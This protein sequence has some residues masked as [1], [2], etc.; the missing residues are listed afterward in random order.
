MNWWRRSLTVANRARRGQ[1]QAV[2]VPNECRRIVLDSLGVALGAVDEPKGRIGIEYGCM[3]GGSG[4]ATIIGI[5]DRVNIFGAAFANGELIKALDMD[6]VLPPGHVSPYVVPGALAVCETLG[7][8]GKSLINALAV[9]HEMSHRLGKAM[10][11]LR[12]TKGGKVSPPPV[13]G[14]SSTV[15][16]APAAIALLK[17]CSREVL[18]TAL[19]T[20]ASISPVNSQVGWFR[21]APR[22]TIKYLLA[23]GALSQPAMTAALMA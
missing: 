11:Y 4:R 14:Y 10:N 13:Y 23:G 16:G 19:G 18:A 5:V 8:S 6:A 12:D 15:F 20:A 2:R 7:V 1:R 22:S 3:I 17:G 9:S 21:H